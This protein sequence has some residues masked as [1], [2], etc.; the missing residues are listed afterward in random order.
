MRQWFL[1]LVMLLGGVAARNITEVTGF[2]LRRQ[3]EAAPAM[4][5]IAPVPWAAAVWLGSAVETMIDTAIW[6][7]ATEPREILGIPKVIWVFVAVVLAMAAFLGCMFLALL[8]AKGGDRG[9][10]Y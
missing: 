3:M 9:A 5:A 1:G 2:S 6:L 7:G 8:C 4:V 10:V